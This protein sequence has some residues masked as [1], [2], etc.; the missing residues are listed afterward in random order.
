MTEARIKKIQK[1]VDSYKELIKPFTIKLINP[2]YPKKPPRALGLYLHDMQ[3]A[4][5]SQYFDTTDPK[6]KSILEMIIDLKCKWYQEEGRKKGWTQGY[7]AKGLDILELLGAE[8]FVKDRIEENRN[9]HDC[10]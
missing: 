7:R 8:E 3:V 4:K 5:G 1:E 9:D 2:V 6:P 10:C